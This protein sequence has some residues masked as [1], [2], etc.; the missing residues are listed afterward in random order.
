[1]EWGLRPQPPKA[2]AV[3]AGVSINRTWYECLRRA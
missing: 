3:A 2:F 1:M